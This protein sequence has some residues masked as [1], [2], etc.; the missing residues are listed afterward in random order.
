MRA[1]L[2]RIIEDNDTRA[3]RALDLV[4]QILIVLSLVSFSIETLPTFRLRREGYCD[5]RRCFA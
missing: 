2:K 4:V 1:T 3:G 5:T